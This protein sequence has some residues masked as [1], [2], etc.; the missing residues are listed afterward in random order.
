MTKKI[1]T[2]QFQYEIQGYQED[3]VNNIVSLFDSLHQKQSFGKFLTEKALK[4]K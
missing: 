1:E 2:K 4:N 3:C